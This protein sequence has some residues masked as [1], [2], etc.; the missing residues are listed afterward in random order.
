[1]HRSSS[2]KRTLALMLA[3][4][5]ILLLFSSTAVT[6]LRAADTNPF[7][8]TLT[9]DEAEKLLDE[10]T[11]GEAQG[12]SLALIGISHS[13]STPPEVAKKVFADRDLFVRN[14]VRPDVARGVYVNGVPRTDGY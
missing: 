13:K 12:V 14:K 1:M 3:T 6:G 11:R 9:V 10:A 4:L 2:S 5:S 8:L 7:T